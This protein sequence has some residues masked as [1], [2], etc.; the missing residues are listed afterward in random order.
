MGRR[1]EIERLGAAFTRS[2]FETIK[3]SFGAEKGIRFIPD[4][5]KQTST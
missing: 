4:L 1:G 5:N 3:R 2:V